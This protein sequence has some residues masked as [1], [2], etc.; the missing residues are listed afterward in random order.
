MF[1]ADVTV[2]KPITLFVSVGEHPLG[3]GCQ[4]QFD[5]GGDFLAQQCATFDFLSNRLNRD[6]RSREEASC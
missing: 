3:F 2:L 6:L 4:R 5:R 1:C